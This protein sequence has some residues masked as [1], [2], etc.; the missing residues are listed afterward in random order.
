MNPGKVIV[1]QFEN[2]TP[3]IDVVDLTPMEALAALVLG[4][5]AVGRS[6]GFSN[7]QLSKTLQCAL[8]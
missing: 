5:I 8:K 2:E 6:L 7:K 1:E 4:Y 3:L